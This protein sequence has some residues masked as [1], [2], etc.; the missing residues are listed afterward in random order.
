MA[1]L[2]DPVEKKA[3]EIQAKQDADELKT[4]DISNLKLEDFQ[5]L[6]QRAAST[7]HP[8][9]GYPKNMVK[10]G[11]CKNG[12]GPK[13]GLADLMMPSYAVVALNPKERVVEDPSGRRQSVRMKGGNERIVDIFAPHNRCVVDYEDGG[14]NT[15]ICFDRTIDLGEGQKLE[16]CA[17]VKSHSARAQIMF[18]LD[19]KGDK[20]QVDTR[21][22]LL[23][24]KQ[25]ARLRRVF[26]MIVNPK[27]KN[28]RL[29]AAI[30]NESDE[31]LDD[32]AEG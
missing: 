21:Y 5:P 11:E 4:F 13:A 9:D 10:V 7:P 15:D 3:G 27:I 20:I 6:Q 8:F 18:A 12:R 28:E 19:I 30:S 1:N 26:E 2:K 25:A 17:F 29:S 14:V 32:L 22:L 23:D 24:T 31:E 16:R